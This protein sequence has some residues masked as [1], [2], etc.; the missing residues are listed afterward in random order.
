M[1]IVVIKIKQKSSWFQRFLAETRKYYK[2]ELE[3]VDF[4]GN[5]EAARLNINQWVEKETQGGVYT[6]IT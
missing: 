2:A 3:S 4:I 1:V 5:H 6:H